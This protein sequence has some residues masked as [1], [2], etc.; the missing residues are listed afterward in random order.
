MRPRAPWVCLRQQARGMAGQ[1]LKHPALRSGG[2]S[3]PFE[4]RAGARFGRRVVRLGHG[5]EPR[6]AG[7]RVPASRP[8]PPCRRRADGGR[9]R[10]RAGL[11]LDQSP[12]F[13]S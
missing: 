13:H 11:T 4:L 1:D 10:R 7:G 8:R 2:Q 12:V 6:P 5:R 3:V 9:T